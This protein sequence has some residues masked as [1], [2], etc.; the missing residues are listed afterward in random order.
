LDFV[1][2]DPK[3]YTAIFVKNTTEAI[4]KLSFRLKDWIKDGIVL[5]TY[6]EHHSNDLPWRTKY[7]IDYVEI[8]EREDYLRPS[9]TSIEKV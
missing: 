8:D 5:S 9:R 6:M 2:A 1:N 7:S 3:Y 4:N